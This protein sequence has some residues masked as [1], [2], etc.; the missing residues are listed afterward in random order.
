[1]LQEL[2]IRLWWAPSFSFESGQSTSESD[3]S[4]VYV[5][6]IRKTPS[7]L[8]GALKISNIEKPLLFALFCINIKLTPTQTAHQALNKVPLIQD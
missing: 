6:K 1:M 3:L 4:D 2:Y 7:Q 8:F 5:T